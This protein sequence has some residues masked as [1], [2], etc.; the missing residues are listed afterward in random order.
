MTW[1]A[2]RQFRTQALVAAGALV[3][4]ALVMVPTGLLGLTTTATWADAEAPARAIATPR[5]VRV[6]RL[7]FMI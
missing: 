2:W 1:L 7:L 3:V 4:L 5:K 6:L